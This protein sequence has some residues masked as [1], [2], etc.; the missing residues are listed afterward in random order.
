MFNIIDVISMGPYLIE[1]AL[2]LIPI[3]VGESK[4]IELLLHNPKHGQ[5]QYGLQVLYCAT[6]QY[7][8]TKGDWTEYIRKDLNEYNITDSIEGLKLVAKTKFENLIKLKQ[9]NLQSNI[10]WK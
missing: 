8:P 1:V 9:E 10:Y 6:I 5:K 3:R 4:K 2:L 7:S